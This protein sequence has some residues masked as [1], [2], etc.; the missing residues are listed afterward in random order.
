MYTTSYG[1]ALD[2]DD[3]YSLAKEKPRVILKWKFL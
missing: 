1:N 2:Q 3:V